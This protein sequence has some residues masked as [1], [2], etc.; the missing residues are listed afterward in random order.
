MHPR[1]TM[2]KLI[3]KIQPVDGD[4]NKAIRYSLSMKSR[5]NKSFD[6]KKLTRI[7]SHSRGTAIRTFSDVDFMALLARNEAK[8]G[9]KV[10]NSSTFLNR[11]RD[12]LIDRFPQTTIRRDLQAVVIEFSDGQHA[13]DVVPAIFSRFMPK[14]GPVYLIPDGYDEWIETSPEIHNKFIMQANEHSS[15]KLIRV[16]QL[17]KWWSA[18]RTSR[19]PIQSFHIEMLLATAKICFGIASYAQCLHDAFKLLTERECRGLRDPL[20]ISGVIYAAKTDAQWEEINN[21]VNYAFEHAK[22]ALYAEAWKN[23]EEANRQWN[24]VF[25]WAM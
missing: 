4:R 17:L 7:G 25:N 13:M 5:L 2:L 3:R 1:I 12:D 24:I 20:G 19:I 18:C 11:M 10:I 23:Y 14:I 6:L 9:G 16:I 8:W 15:S 21:A 22:K